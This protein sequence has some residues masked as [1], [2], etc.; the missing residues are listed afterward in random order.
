[1]RTVS[2]FFG[3]SEMCKS[4]PVRDEAFHDCGRL[5]E[6]HSGRN[7]SRHPAADNPHDTVADGKAGYFV[8][9]G[10]HFSQRPQGRGCYCPR[11]SERHRRLHVE[12]GLRD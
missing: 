2:L 9:D 4:L 6:G 12:E 11:K 10:C 1:M 7:G 3:S 8:S 5:D